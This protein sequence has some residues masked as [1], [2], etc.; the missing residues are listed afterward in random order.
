MRDGGG[1]RTPPS[2]FPQ[3][4]FPLFP[5]ASSPCKRVGERERKE[6]GREVGRRRRLH[7]S[8]KCPISYSA[9]SYPSHSPSL[10]PPLPN[11]FLLPPLPP[12]LSSPPNVRLLSS[13]PFPFNS[14]AASSSSGSQPRE[15]GSLK[16]ANSLSL[17]LALTE[18]A[19][20]V[21]VLVRPPP[22]PLPFPG[23]KK[24]GGRQKDSPTL[25]R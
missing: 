15:G 25:S 9:C 4:R 7:L 18:E 5:Q 17:S 19:G 3:T 22:E 6:E 23:R 10:P 12:S 24:G 2:P 20:V 14:G 1:G 11:P 13:S 16:P 21:L 8:L